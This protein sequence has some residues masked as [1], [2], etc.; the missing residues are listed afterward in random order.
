MYQALPNKEVNPIEA[1]NGLLKPPP[2]PPCWGK[3]RTTLKP[4]KLIHHQTQRIFHK[5]IW[6]RK[7]FIYVL[8]MLLNCVFQLKQFEGF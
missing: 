6:E 3:R 5:I 7:L 1:G 4:F 2:P 8:I